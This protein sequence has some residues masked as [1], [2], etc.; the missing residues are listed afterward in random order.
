MRWEQQWGD[1]LKTILAHAEKTGR[2]PGTIANAPVPDDLYL[3]FWEAFKETGRHRPVYV[4]MGGVIFGRIPL[5]TVY[6][7]LDENG[8]FDP[9]IRRLYL[10]VIARLD[11]EHVDFLNRSRNQP[12]TQ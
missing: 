7:W 3:G 12:Q 5:Q 6:A 8:I 11:D 9:E 10:D 2:V 4:G 1:H